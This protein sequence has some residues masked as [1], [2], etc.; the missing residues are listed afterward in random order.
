LL[1]AREYAELAGFGVAFE[2][3]IAA[4]LADFV[5][6]ADPFSRIW[7]ARDE[8]AVVGSIAV[9]RSHSPGEAHLRWFLINHEYRHASPWTIVDR[10]GLTD[11]GNGLVR[12]DRTGPFVSPYSHHTR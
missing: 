7:L 5:K 9:D 12:T 3:L 6:R 4:D 11:P 1:H 10:P 2:A 8:G